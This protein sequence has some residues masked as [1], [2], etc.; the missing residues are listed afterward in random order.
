M[1]NLSL[2][3]EVSPTDIIS[4]L[5]SG[6]HS[7]ETGDGKRTACMQHQDF[8]SV[9]N[10]H[11]DHVRHTFNEFRQKRNVFHKL[12]HPRTHRTNKSLDSFH[13]H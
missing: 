3:T 13:C 5:A 7:P 2:Q 9:T 6:P 8:P 1:Y 12:H 10:R 4:Q 11:T